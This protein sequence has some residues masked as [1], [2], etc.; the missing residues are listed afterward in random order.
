MRGSFLP[1]RQRPWLSVAKLDRLTDEL[2]LVRCQ[3][4]DHEGLRRAH[5]DADDVN[6]VLAALQTRAKSDELQEQDEEDKCIL[7][8]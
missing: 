4:H 2:L 8:N 7:S 6:E 3:H 5:I 1:A